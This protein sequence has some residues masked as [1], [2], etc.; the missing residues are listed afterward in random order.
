MQQ[1]TFDVAD[2]ILRQ[3]GLTILASPTGN[4]TTFANHV[5]KIVGLCAEKQMISVHTTTVVTAM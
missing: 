4:E 3:N 2:L 5:G 1:Q